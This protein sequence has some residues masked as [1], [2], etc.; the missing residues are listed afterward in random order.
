MNVSPKIFVLFT[1]ASLSLGSAFA[2]EKAPSHIDVFREIGA[3]QLGL[4][5]VVAS[6]GDVYKAR[7]K[8]QGGRVSLLLS[9]CYHSAKLVTAK[10]NIDLLKGAKAVTETDKT[11]PDT[12]A[13]YDQ[14]CETIL[15]KRLAQDKAKAAERAKN[16]EPQQKPNQEPN[17]A[18]RIWR[19]HSGKIIVTAI[20]L[21]LCV[22]SGLCVPF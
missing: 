5:F 22:G 11:Y 1:L 14:Q 21:G 18:Q 19:D 10:Q 15:A 4:K 7:F 2:Q 9:R 8:R 3:Y 20:A 6:N 12:A 16:R 17:F 13:A